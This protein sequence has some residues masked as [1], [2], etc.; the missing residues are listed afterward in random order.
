MQPAITLAWP[1]ADW[2]GYDRVLAAADLGYAGPPFNWVT[3]PDQFTLAAFERA[4]LDAADRAAGLR[5]D[6]ADLL[7]RALD[8]DPRR[9]CP[10]TRSATAARS[11]RWRAAGPTPEAVWSDLDRVRDQFA[12]AI[13][14]SLRTV[15]AFAERRAGDD[16]PRRR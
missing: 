12:R 4:E 2:F 6:R 7:A 3:M 13:D 16:R 11:P 9:C 5:R 1:E 8:A 14:Y 15:G 10:G